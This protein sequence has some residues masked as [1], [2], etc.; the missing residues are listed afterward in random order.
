MEGFKA[1]EVAA[2]YI[3]KITWLFRPILKSMG[4]VKAN[5]SF[6]D[7][8]SHCNSTP[9]TCRGGLSGWC[10]VYNAPV[11]VQYDCLLMTLHGHQFKLRGRLPGHRIRTVL[12]M[13]SIL[14]IKGFVCCIKS[15]VTYSVLLLVMSVLC[16]W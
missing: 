5:E 10:N 7:V 6:D 12:V 15:D 8:N 13:M 16:L 3:H 2:I 9:P 4:A 14:S 1:A 11:T